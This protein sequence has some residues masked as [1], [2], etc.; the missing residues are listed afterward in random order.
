MSSK[1]AFAA[2]CGCFT[3]DNEFLNKYG[4]FF[5]EPLLQ[6]CKWKSSVSLALLLNPEYHHRIIQLY[7]P[8]NYFGTYR[9]DESVMK[10]FFHPTC[11]YTKTVQCFWLQWRLKNAS[12]RSVEP[13]APALLHADLQSL[14]Y[15]WCLLCRLIRSALFIWK[16]YYHCFHS[17]ERWVSNMLL[18]QKN[19]FI[20]LM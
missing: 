20:I 10:I 9:W 2:H 13:L 8:L 19:S 5:C 15:E 11:L 1:R 4:R 7:T 16:T 6:H 14:K 12:I 17:R 3:W 18:K